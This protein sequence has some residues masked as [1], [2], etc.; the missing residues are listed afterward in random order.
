[1]D[2]FFSTPPAA[3]RLAWKDMLST[4]EVAKNAAAVGHA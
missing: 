3:S 1:L 2:D 4:P